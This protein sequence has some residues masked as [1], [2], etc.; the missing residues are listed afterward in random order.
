M[1]GPKSSSAHCQIWQPKQ[2]WSGLISL[3]L[4]LW[5][6]NYLIIQ[7]VALDRYFNAE[8]NSTCG[9]YLSYLDSQPEQTASQNNLFVLVCRKTISLTH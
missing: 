9:I 7:V 6:L 4:G 1:T 8:S 5:L 2:D 3:T